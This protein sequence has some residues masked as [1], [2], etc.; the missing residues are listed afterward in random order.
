MASLR[1]YQG[2]IHSCMNLAQLKIGRCLQVNN[3]YWGLVTYCDTVQLVV[4]HKFFLILTFR[5]GE[6]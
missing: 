1:Y 6:V 4:R 3:E 5:K 2:Y